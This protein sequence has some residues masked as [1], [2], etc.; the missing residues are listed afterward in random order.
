MQMAVP[1]V[2]MGLSKRTC[3]ILSRIIAASFTSAVGA[4]SLWFLA[5]NIPKLRR[6][7]IRE[8]AAPDGA[9]E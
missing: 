8:Y 6:S 9:D 7:D 5:A 2:S 1:S 4:A 3:E